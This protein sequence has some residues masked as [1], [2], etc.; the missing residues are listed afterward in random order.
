MVLDEVKAN[1]EVLIQRSNAGIVLLS[2]ADKKTINK[3][4]TAIETPSAS[5][6]KDIALLLHPDKISYFLPQ[7]YMKTFDKS[8]KDMEKLL[9]A[10]LNEITKIENHASAEKLLP[11]KIVFNFIH[12]QNVKKLEPLLPA[13]IAAYE[14]IAVNKQKPSDDIEKRM[15]DNVGLFIGR[16]METQYTYA[17]KFLLI[18]FTLFPTLNIRD[19]QNLDDIMS[20]MV[21]FVIGQNDK[22]FSRE[23]LYLIHSKKPF[24]YT[25]EDKK[26]IQNA[27]ILKLE[28]IFDRLFAVNIISFDDSMTCEQAKKLHI[29][30]IL[31]RKKMSAAE[32]EFHAGI[33][34]AKIPAMEKKKNKL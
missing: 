24:F 32:Y 25:E 26:I 30:K 29:L 9:Q 28:K 2:A 1:L 21:N 11:T 16:S 17:Q 14:K 12:K 5:L 33:K 6:K 3:I 23:L 10:A 20:G 18:I 4:I 8:A 19:K 34:S 22:L 13:Y 7:L 31:L 27:D 15:F